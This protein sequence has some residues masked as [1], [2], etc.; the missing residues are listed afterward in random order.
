MPISSLS[1]IAG[2]SERGLR[3]AFYSVRSIAPKQWML[4]ERLKGV[5]RVLSD[6]C[7]GAVTVTRAASDFGFFELGRFAA[8]YRRAFGEAPSATLRGTRRNAHKTHAPIHEG[9]R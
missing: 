1:R 5:R 8:T 2:L 6:G 3:N 9:G 7:S 4:A